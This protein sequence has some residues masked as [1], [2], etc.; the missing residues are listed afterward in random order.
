MNCGQ[1]KTPGAM[2]GSQFNYIKDYTS[3]L[4]KRFSGVFLCLIAIS[5]SKEYPTIELLGDYDHH[6]NIESEYLAVF[7]DIQEYT[8][9]DYTIGFYDV[10]IAWL[11]EQIKY[12]VKLRSVLHVGDITWSN[13][14]DQWYLFNH[15]TTPLANI[16]PYYTCIGNHDYTW[17]RG[18]SIPDRE[19]TEINTFAHFPST[20]NG[21]IEYYENGHLENY[22]AKLY[23]S[24]TDVL[25]LVLEYGPRKDVLSWA[26]EYVGAHQD[27]RF[28]LLTHEWLT[29]SGK[30]ISSGSYA[31]AQFYGHSSYSTPEEVWQELV[32]PYDNI[33][34]V[35]C[36][37]NGFSTQLF[38][39]N[40]SG[41]EVSQVL[42]N[43]Q[44]QENGG[45]GLIQLWEIPA[46]SDSIY[47]RNYDVLHRDWYLSDSV[48]VSFKYIY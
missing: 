29:S 21:I 3:S 33:I 47:I 43:L 24:D 20:D 36:G 26:K 46:A 32:Y 41:R 9:N 4:K 31:E 18:S 44:Y 2:N 30:R 14:K 7:G 22:V 35:L 39:P 42:F 23:L 1:E 40:V 25:L 48:S 6:L 27:K 17:G 10:T 38:S 5:C 45:N 37:H 19:A 15:S 11:L 12:N 16:I 8:V 13:A 34:C 28:V